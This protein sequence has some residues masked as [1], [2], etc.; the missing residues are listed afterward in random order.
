ML[1]GLL[2]ALA[3]TSCRLL[4]RPT[5]LSE[6][7]RKPVFANLDAPYGF[8]NKFAILDWQFLA[9]GSFNWSNGA[10]LRNFEETRF[11]DDDDDVR[12]YSAYFESMWSRAEPYR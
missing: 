4:C 1:D 2:V 7:A 12:A 10:E 8:G 9:T 11:T 6:H 5:K 3:R